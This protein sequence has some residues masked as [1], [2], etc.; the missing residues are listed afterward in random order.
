MSYAFGV[1]VSQIGIDEMKD[2][3]ELVPACGWA[4]VHVSMNILLFLIK[5]NFR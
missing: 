2:Y 4:S 1:N 3:P 5:L